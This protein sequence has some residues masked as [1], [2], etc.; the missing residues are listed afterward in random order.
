M[1]T[2]RLNI[3]VVNPDYYRSSG[4]TV[5]IKRIHQS[6][7]MHG[8]ENFFVDCGYSAA[9]HQD[10]SWMPEN[11]LARFDLMSMSPFR[12][13]Y[14]LGRFFFWLKSNNIDILHV[15]HRRLAAV[16]NVCGVLSGVALVYSAN[17]TYK[18]N[19]WFWLFGPKSVIAITRSVA[20]NVSDTTRAKNIAEIGNPTMFPSVCPD[21]RVLANARAAI[22]VARLEEVK[23]HRFLIQ[24]WHL[25][26][27]RGLRY[28]LLLVGEGSLMGELRNLTEEL[29]LASLITFKGYLS[30]V[31]PLYE[32]SL[33]SILVSS[34]EGQGIVTV[35]A[36]AAGRASLLTDVDGSRD[37][38]P[39]VRGLPNGV[40]FGDVAALAKLIEYWFSHSSEV[41][42]EG[43]VFFE[44]HKSVNSLDAVG[45]RYA[46]A[47]RR[48]I[49]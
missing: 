24:A 38:L 44:F 43:Q 39:P 42:A 2:R 4:V 5:A 18:F 41:L 16:L 3:C 48:L 25:L 19:V 31:D 23:G 7:S 32:Q 40:P 10:V 26:A 37:C 20:D 30:D 36:A 46:S 33:F 14:E 21:N 12:L 8:I 17:S 28:Q 47:Y 15:H 11:R 45:E 49:R 27:K 29:G 34:V 6:V 13:I 1:S 35:E 9:A 22:C